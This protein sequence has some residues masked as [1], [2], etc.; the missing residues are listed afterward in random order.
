MP[1]HISP[2]IRAGDIQRAQALSKVKDECDPRL[3]S[4][5][6]VAI[7]ESYAGFLTVDQELGKHLFFWF[8]PSQSNA[9]APLNIWLNGG[10]GVTSMLGLFWEN[11]PLRPK[12]RKKATPKPGESKHRSYAW[13][14]VS[15]YQ[16]FVPRETSWVGPFSML[17]ID[18]PVSTGY[19]YVERENPNE[20]FTQSS[21][22]EDLYQFVEQFYLLFPNYWTKQLYI[23]GQSYAG[24]YVPALA[25][26]IHQ[27]IRR[28]QS[29]IPLT[30]IYMGGP[31]YAPEIMLPS[32]AEYLYSTGAFSRA[33]NNRALYETREYLKQSYSG[34]I[35]RHKEELADAMLKTF[36]NVGI[37]SRDN[38]V[39]GE[40]VDYIAVQDIMRSARVRQA[41]H[42]GN[43]TFNSITDSK[44]DNKFNF[45]FLSSTRQKMEVLLDMGYKILIFN[46]DFDAIT[47]S[48]MVEEA[49]LQTY[50]IGLEE[51]LDA[52]R[53][54]W[55]G[56]R[57]DKTDPKKAGGNRQMY[58]FVTR[59]RNLCRVVVHGAGH[60][61]PHDQPD[62]T[63]MMMQQFAH[64]GCI[65]L[66]TNRST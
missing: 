26:R 57:N 27:A 23:G 22:A 59:T 58:G 64:T 25:Y 31:F 66:P 17:Y 24:K 51:Y 6:D 49:L 37:P 39:T 11:G 29:E 61:V 4:D 32:R 40:A 55:Y 47:T 7:P 14:N 20:F 19:S 65:D 33:E 46:G 52:S 44:Q 53:E 38:Y 62:I 50:W 48:R 5:C 3:R 34:G 35:D 56:P 12:H 18:N 42:A 16:E 45:D 43:R 36:F 63:L 60:Q 1:L 13:L 54:I 41:V 8:F 30:G 10:P 9:S 15:I 28:G 2:Y 21:Y